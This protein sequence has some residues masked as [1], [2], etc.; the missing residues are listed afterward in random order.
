MQLAHV[1]RLWR[2]LRHLRAEQLL[3]RVWFRLHRPRPDLR[4]APALRVPAPVPVPAPAGAWQAPAQREASVLGPQRFLFLNVEHTL[5]AGAAAWDDVRMERLWRY[6]LHYFD[7]LNAVGHAERS[8]WHRELVPRWTAQNPPGQGTGW[9]P[10][11]T[12]LRIVNW[13]KW[14]SGGAT[15]EPA[16]LDNLAI[17]V[18]WLCGRLEWHL[19]GNHLFANAKALVMAGLF[20]DGP[21]A[22]GWLARGLAILERELPE[23]I[24]PDGGQFE[25]SPMYHALALEDLLDLIN[26]VRARAGPQSSAQIQAQALLPALAGRASKMLHWLRCMTRPDGSLAHFNDSAAGIAPHATELERYAGALGITAPQPDARLVHL[27]HLASSGYIRATCGTAVLLADVAPLG[28]DYL[29][30]HAHADTLSF[31][32]SLDAQNLVVNGGASRYGL[33]PERLRERGTA[34]HSTVQVAGL[35]SSEVWSGFRV[36]RRARPFGLKVQQ[37]EQKQS[38]TP[39]QGATFGCAHNGYQHLPG[40]PQHHRQWALENGALQ[41]D[42][43]LLS[44]KLHARQPVGLP[45]GLTIALPAIARFH[46]APGLALQAAGSNAWNVLLGAQ[47]VA[48]VKVQA[49]RGRKAVGQHA[50]RFGVTVA[51]ET[52][53]VELQDGVASTCWS[54]NTDAHSFPD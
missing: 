6:N 24:L 4:P 3:G 2:T 25:R 51:I 19:L 33:G 29:V 47:Q 10:Y 9:E 1:G 54:W 30:G 26:M 14:F 27:T 42:D 8:A 40:A 20:F 36:G 28:P 38:Q 13:I 7:D 21:E 41:V 18:R 49:G 44:A 50:P 37:Q 17:Q 31:E 32:L 46:L 23:Q 34:A 53:E 43:R 11:P 5:D 48:H 52:L 15:A 16:W 35:D 12:S 22:E 39:Y 45:D